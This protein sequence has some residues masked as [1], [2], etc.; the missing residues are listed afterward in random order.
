MDATINNPANRLSALAGSK[1]MIVRWTEPYSMA[2]ADFIRFLGA[3]FR[4]NVCQHAF[5]N[6]GLNGSKDYSFSSGKKYA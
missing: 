3:H 5:Q 6:P 1:S 4:T 2:C